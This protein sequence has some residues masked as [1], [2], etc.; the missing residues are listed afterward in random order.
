MFL[1]VSYG[2]V[3]CLIPRKHACLDALKVITK[4]EK[5]FL[6]LGYWSS[7]KCKILHGKILVINFLHNVLSCEALKFAGASLIFQ[8]L[9]AFL[10]R[11]WDF[12][13]IFYL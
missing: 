7:T 6:F 8:S 2:V 10:K 11:E 12:M 3:F 1:L 5:E 4:S 13:E 9:T